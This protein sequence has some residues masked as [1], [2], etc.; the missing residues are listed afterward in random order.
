MFFVFHCIADPFFSCVNL[1]C[2]LTSYTPGA[3]HVCHPGSTFDKNM[4]QC[5]L[6]PPGTFSVHGLN[7][8]AC[9]PSFYS[10]QAGAAQCLYCPGSQTTKG[11]KGQA[12]CEAGSMASTQAIT[13]AGASLN[14]YSAQVCWQRG[15]MTLGDILV[16]AGVL[17]CNRCG[18]DLLA[19][20]PPSLK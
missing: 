18:V 20:L 16:Y 2:P 8:I 1:C 3:P 10:P 14:P 13:V 12:T 15:C 11:V 17:Y 5:L 7:C 19:C 6:C 9:P 4:Q